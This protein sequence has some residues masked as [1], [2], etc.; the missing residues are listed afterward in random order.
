MKSGEKIVSASSKLLLVG[1]LLLGS[2]VTPSA[3]FADK[4]A[5]TKIVVQTNYE[6]HSIKPGLFGVN[7]RYFVDGVGMWDPVTQSVYP[8][9]DEKVA[10]LGLKAI[11]YPGG[12]TA[13]LFWWKRSIGL[14]QQRLNQVNPY[15]GNGPEK[16]NFGLDEALRFAE[17]HRYITTYVYNVG[18]GNPQ[19]AAD[20]SNI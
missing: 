16:A 18:N 10:D 7:H 9:F 20:W 17:K 3:A 13:N 15:L 14:A 12:T 8:D 5:S 4:A 11:R 19:D 6:L 2:A 1:S